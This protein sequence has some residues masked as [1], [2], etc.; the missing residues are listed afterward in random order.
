L[1]FSRYSSSSFSFSS[2]SGVI[3]VSRANSPRFG[4]WV[5]LLADEKPC[6]PAKNEPAPT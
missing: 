3:N 4:L 1:S 6:Y 5:G 2:P